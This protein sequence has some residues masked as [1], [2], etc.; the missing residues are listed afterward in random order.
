MRRLIP[1][2]VLVLGL[3]A[4]VPAVLTTVDRGPFER[5]PVGRE[6]LRWDGAQA[7]GPARDA[8]DRMLTPLAGAELGA[9][10]S[11]RH[12]QGAVLLPLLAG[13]VFLLALPH[14]G[15]WYAV[16]SGLLSVLM[17]PIV[18]G[19][20]ALVPALP[21]AVA[22]LAGL[23]VLDRRRG[24]LGWA[25]A[26]FG[27][28]LAASLEPGLGWGAILLLFV[29]ALI[30]PG[31]TR[32]PW[33]LIA[34]AVAWMGAGLAVGT[35]GSA[36]LPEVSGVEAYQGHRAAASGVSPRRGD[37]DEG[38][39]WTYPDFRRG[40]I[41]AADRSVGAG[42]VQVH[43]WKRAVEEGFRHPLSEAR[44]GA[45]HLLTSFQADPL[46]R[47]VSVAYL[48]QRTDGDGLLPLVWL[49][50]FLLPLGLVGFWIGRRRVSA[51]LL[52]AL[53]SGLVAATLTFADPDTR[54]LTVAGLV[55]GVGLFLRTM[56]SGPASSRWMGAALA[57]PAVLV[58]GLWPARGGVPGMQVQGDDAYFLGVLYDT[59]QRGSVAQREFDRALRID[60][61][62]PYPLLA[63]ASMLARDQL[64]EEASRQLEPLVQRHPRF[65]PG[66]LLLARLYEQQQDWPEGARI[67]E[68]LLQ[69]EPWN[70]ELLNNYG[71]ILIQMGLYEEGAAAL[72]AAL[73]ADP[74]YQLARENLE[75]L[76]ARGFVPGAPPSGDPL[77]IAQ[78][79]ILSR[80]REGNTAAAEDSLQAAY[81][82]FG[83]IPQLLYLEGLL[84]LAQGRGNEAVERMKPLH[85]SMKNDA[86]FLNNLGSAY[87][88]AGD[89]ASARRVW[90]EGLR[91]QPDN[92]RIRRNLASLDRPD[93]LDTAPGR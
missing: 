2:L 66:L 71:T 92:F 63:L 47:D 57:V 32:R 40:A 4:L 86:L 6:A 60:P 70:A 17:A 42:E 59:E 3:G 75:G 9:V 58:W 30:R 91:L 26:G 23:V 82:T 53:L 61:D 13:L 43:W 16:A 93:T 24:L 35:L 80:L 5:T 55:V 45:L 10:Q 29:A 87:A 44:R 74:N 34:L 33:A 73:R 46:P 39:W 83:R 25:A 7:S 69:L 38:R 27:A 20:T 15:A 31:G 56:G 90:E 85:E 78:E 36:S 28:A 19:S 21:A 1:V 79:G 54:L 22:A 65:Y 49:T 11:A 89:T 67:Y 14:V 18:L 50:R 37:T 41:R 72:E 52:V 64:Y 84:R 77:R 12:R 8:Y 88:T 68:R 62:N 48:L 81:G 51:P 76:K